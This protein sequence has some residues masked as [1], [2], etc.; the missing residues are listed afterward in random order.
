MSPEFPHDEPLPSKDDHETAAFAQER[1]L[2]DVV[3]PR[4]SLGPRFHLDRLVEFDATAP[5]SYPRRFTNDHTADRYFHLDNL[6]AGRRD[7]EAQTHDHDRSDDDES[8]D[9]TRTVGAQRNERH[10]DPAADRR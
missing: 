10:D 1:S 2:G 7:A 3:Q 5:S 8:D 6:G 4:S 9:A